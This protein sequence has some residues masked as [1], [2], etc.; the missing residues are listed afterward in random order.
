MIIH[1]QRFGR[2]AVVSLAIVSGVAAGMLAS[3]R[4]QA[5]VSNE[6]VLHQYCSAAMAG[7]CADSDIQIGCWVISP[8]NLC[9]GG[10]CA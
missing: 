5:A 8:P 9:E 3:S 1:H 10:G 7:S 4:V 6:C 2:S